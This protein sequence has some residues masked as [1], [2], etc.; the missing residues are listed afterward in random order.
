MDRND[1][2]KVKESILRSLQK[3]VQA[4]EP[5]P[6]NEIHAHAL[7]RGNLGLQ[8]EYLTGLTTHLV[9]KG[10]I[11]EV[12]SGL[13]ECHDPE[14][15]KAVMKANKRG[16]LSKLMGMINNGPKKKKAVG[17]AIDRMD[18]D[19]RR[20]IVAVVTAMKRL[21][22]GKGL[23]RKDMFSDS[24]LSNH[25]QHGTVKALLEAGTI[26]KTGEKRDR[27]YWSTDRSLDVNGI[28]GVLWPDKVLEENLA[29]R[30]EED[31]REPEP[32]PASPQAAEV[33][34][35]GSGQELKR[36]LQDALEQFMKIAEYQAE[37]IE[38][39]EGTV[40]ALIGAFEAFATE[41]GS[42]DIA[43][44]LHAKFRENS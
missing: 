20:R 10:W 23:T 30:V 18:P 32:E 40:E 6:F 3:I 17:R 9:K 28:I 38:K 36:E 1:E 14:T 35:T 15:L 22:Q 5:I 34:K 42:P 2:V 39:L 41:L 21:D 43:K 8:K 44:S 19:E 24:D 29:A 13:Y 33:E 31:L 16:S 27:R 26:L 4:E 12:E 11:I 7:K 25:W 37:R